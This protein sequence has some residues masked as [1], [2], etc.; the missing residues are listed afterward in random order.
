MDQT[1]VRWRLH[2]MNWTGWHVFM[3]LALQWEI[4]VSA[5]LSWYSSM[6]SVSGKSSFRSLDWLFI[7]YFRLICVSILPIDGDTIAYGSKDGGRTMHRSN[8]TLN[9]LMEQVKASSS[10]PPNNTNN[11]CLGGHEIKFAR[12]PRRIQPPCVYVR[13][14]SHSNSRC[15]TKLSFAPPLLDQSVM[16]L[17]T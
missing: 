16:V 10:V 4:R 6:N 14:T 11:Y 1:N 12:T 2:H 17:A 15:L 3:A 9:K 5:C 13:L 7:S 8:E